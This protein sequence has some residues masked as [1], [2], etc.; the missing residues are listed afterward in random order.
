MRTTFE[1]QDLRCKVYVPTYN[2]RLASKINKENSFG[3]SFNPQHQ[4]VYSA[5]SIH[6][7]VAFRENLHKHNSTDL[8]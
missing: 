1:I 7:Y 8:R 6:T 4:H 3:K 5:Q 2:P